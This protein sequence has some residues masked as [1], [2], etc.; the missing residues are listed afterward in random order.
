MQ[1]IEKMLG[2]LF[3]SVPPLPE[4][5]RKGLAAATPGLAIAGG[6]LSLVGAW[7]VFQLITRADLYLNG[8]YSTFG[9]TAPVA[10]LSGFGPVAW[11]TI[12]ILVAQAVLAFMAFPALRTHKKSGW[13]LLLMMA[14]ASVAYGVVANLLG[15]YFNLG[16]LVLA[17]L[18]SAVG[19]YVLFQVRSYFGGAEAATKPAT[20]ATPAATPPKTDKKA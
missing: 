13:N 2:D 7:Y 8:L 9:Y 6:V 11:L 17:L 19:L 15:G 20:P 5:A 12:G 4:E 16:G 1:A 3:K 10:G 18:G 14:L